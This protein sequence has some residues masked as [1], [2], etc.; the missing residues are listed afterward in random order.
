LFGPCRLAEEEEKEAPAPREVEVNGYKEVETP[1]GFT[2]KEGTEVIL[3][4][5]ALVAVRGVRSKPHGTCM[6]SECSLS[7]QRRW[8]RCKE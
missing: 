4:D 2:F 7:G 1:I 3:V 8:W 5:K 6:V